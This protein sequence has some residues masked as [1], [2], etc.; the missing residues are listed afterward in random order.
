MLLKITYN[1][2][3]FNITIVYI[4]KMKFLKINTN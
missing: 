1:N 2:L 3:V 4:K